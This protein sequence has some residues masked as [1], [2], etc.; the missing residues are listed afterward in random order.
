MAKEE[1]KKNTITVT[2]ARTHT[3]GGVQHAAGDV[4]ELTAAQVERLKKAGTIK[5]AEVQKSG[6]AEVNTKKKEA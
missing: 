5:S 6:S 3:H 4:L 2:L 1:I